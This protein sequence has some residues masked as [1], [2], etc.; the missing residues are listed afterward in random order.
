MKVPLTALPAFFVQ[1]ADLWKDYYSV[2]NK[3]FQDACQA[4]IDL[5][6]TAL[7]PGVV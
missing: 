2:V 7:H 4:E 6:G 1:N 3:I 5:W